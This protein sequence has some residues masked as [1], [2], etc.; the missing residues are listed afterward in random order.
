MRNFVSSIHRFGGIRTHN[1]WFGW[2][3]SNAVQ[4]T[5]SREGGLIEP[6][7]SG[8]IGMTVNNALLNFM[9]SLDGIRTHD[10]WS[11]RKVKLHEH[12]W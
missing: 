11:G 12:F 1:L 9:A 7:A 10:I 6:A 5:D 3:T 2:K 4:C 8:S